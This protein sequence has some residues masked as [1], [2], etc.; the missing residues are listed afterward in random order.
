MSRGVGI[1]NF[2]NQLEQAQPAPPV[3][4]IEERHFSDV[5][6]GIRFVAQSLMTACE[7]CEAHYGLSEEALRAALRVDGQRAISAL[8]GWLGA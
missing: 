3:A 1:E 5:V 2:L 7:A 6:A 4:P 8:N